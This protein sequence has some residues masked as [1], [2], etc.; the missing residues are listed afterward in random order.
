MREVR[1]GDYLKAEE[2]REMDARIN[3]A[4]DGGRWRLLLARGGR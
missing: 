2:E 1:A 4:K 3:T